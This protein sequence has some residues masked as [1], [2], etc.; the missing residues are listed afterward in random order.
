[1]P[2]SDACDLINILEN[3]SF[4]FTPRSLGSGESGTP[5]ELEVYC[6]SNIQASRRVIHSVHDFE[7]VFEATGLVQSEPF[8]F[9]DTEDVFLFTPE[10]IIAS[11]N[12]V[13]QW[14]DTTM[15]N[16]NLGPD[17]D[18]PD[19]GTLNGEDAVLLND[20]DDDLISSDTDV[21]PTD[22][23][24]DIYLW[25]VFNTTDSNGTIFSQVFGDGGNVSFRVH[26]FVD[27]LRV[28]NDGSTVF[29]STTDVANGNNHLMELQMDASGPAN[30]WTLKIDGTQEAQATE[31]GG[32]G[33]NGGILR[34]GRFSTASAGANPANIAFM[35]CTDG[36]TDTDRIDAIRTALGEKF[37]IPV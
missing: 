1:M 5:V 12:K 18:N 33:G 32:V 19:L 31:A 36:L 30:N 37:N 4:D 14:T 2:E 34:L 3:G 9:S 8:E 24:K 23:S 26:I 27:N 6:V 20:D 15:N 10:S 28:S 16:H 7:L 25:I 29:T 22:N 11:G 13:I 17:S 21:I 35:K